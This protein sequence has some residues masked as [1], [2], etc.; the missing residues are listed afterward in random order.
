MTVELLRSAY[1]FGSNTYL[2]RI[3]DG[4]IAVDP[5]APVP[6]GIGQ[7]D[8]KY[9]FLSH[10]HIDHI[11]TLTEWVERTGATV[12]VSSQD[13][14]MLSDPQLNCYGLFFGGNGGYFGD[15]VALNDGDTLT[16]SGRHLKFVATPGHTAG[17]GILVCDKTAFVGDTVFAGGGFGRWDLPTGDPTQLMRSIKTVTSLPEDILLY[18]GHGVSCTVKE[19]KEQFKYQKV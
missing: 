11:L 4:L 19:F 9:I 3:G 13:Q 15:S 6:Q 7:G 1:P 2:V 10:G 16:V 17:S 5:S 8:V 18:P 12:V 14:K